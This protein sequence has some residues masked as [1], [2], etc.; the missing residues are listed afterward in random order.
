[1]NKTTLL[2]NI[3]AKQTGYKYSSNISL[4]DISN[5]VLRPK[6]ESPLTLDKRLEYRIDVTLGAIVGIEDDEFFND[7]LARAKREIGSIIA[8]EVYGEIREELVKLLYELK[9]D[10]CFINSPLYNK[11]EKIIEMTYYD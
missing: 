1:M 9:K 5:S 7:N 10:L 8:K 2:E 3:S 11:V 6:T 4:L